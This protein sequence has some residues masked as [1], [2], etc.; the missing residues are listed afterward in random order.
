MPSTLYVID[1]PNGKKYFGIT[2]GPL[3]YRWKAHRYFASKRHT[4]A[5]GKLPIYNA[6]SK[7]PNA[8]IKALVIGDLEYIKELEIASIALWNTRDNRYGYNVS[9]GGDLGG[10]EHH[11]E[12]T[13]RKI[14]EASASRIRSLE[15]NAK[16]SE[17]LKGHTVSEETRK[18][19]SIRT[20]EAMN[21]PEV[22]AK[23]RAP[24]TRKVP[25]RRGHSL[26]EEHKNKIGEGVKARWAK[27]RAQK[28][29]ILRAGAG[30]EARKS[31]DASSDAKS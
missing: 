26:S 16:T 9:R 4:P 28:E 20:K 24:K 10:L 7:Y 11:T 19:I 22:K 21:N 23:V 5:S 29:E 14:S 27:I 13:K 31:R 6:L 17:K 18:L 1:F 15:S 12:E 25:P 8:E 2:S 3:E 30:I